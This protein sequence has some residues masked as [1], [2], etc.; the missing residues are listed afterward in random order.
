VHVVHNWRG[1]RDQ[2]RQH[3]TINMQICLHFAKGILQKTIRETGTEV[4]YNV[5]QARMMPELIEQHITG[6]QI[7]FTYTDKKFPTYDG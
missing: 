6:N 7:Q 4:R 1:N 2:K 3:A 5:K